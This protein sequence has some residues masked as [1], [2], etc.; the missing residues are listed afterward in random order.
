METTA[1]LLR[2]GSP[3]AGA[4]ATGSAFDSIGEAVRSYLRLAA[5]PEIVRDPWSRLADG[6]LVRVH[7]S[8]WDGE[9]RLSADDLGLD[10]TTYRDVLSRIRWGGLT[11]LPENG[12]RFSSLETRFRRLPERWGVAVHWGRFV[13]VSAWESFRRDWDALQQEWEEL[14]KA[15]EESYDS[16]RAAA[17]KAAYAFA[18]SSATHARRLG[19][20]SSAEEAEWRARLAERILAHYPPVDEIRRRFA[21]S[22]ET[23][24]IPR[25]SLDLE[26]TH[27][28]EALQEA[29]RQRLAELQRQATLA[30][31][32]DHAERLRLEREIDDM[33]AHIRAREA[34]IREELSRMRAEARARAQR[35]LTHFEMTYARQIRERLWSSLQHV[36]AA[37]QNGRMTPMATSSLR[38]TIQELRQIA[39]A[40][41]AEIGAMLD[42]LDRAIGPRGVR[43][44]DYGPSPADLERQ[45]ADMGMLLQTSIIALG[46]HVRRGGTATAPI[47][48]TAGDA[49]LTI[50]VRGAV[51]RLDLPASL[52]Q[53]LVEQAALTRAEL[54]RLS[55]ARMAEEGAATDCATRHALP[56]RRG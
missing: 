13:P 2:N 8:R 36:A 47:D 10:A 50:D 11:L 26:E 21:V 5:P 37:L 20:L 29:Q 18:A 35:L 56:D 53:T 46:G 27:R 49:P 38:R 44:R 9:V 23:A 31:L 43:R 33:T 19:R 14:L 4:T 42:R 22:Y 32:R 6:L 3:V 1:T 52:A 45:I 7:V 34:V 48:A 16:A 24:I 30:A 54:R 41:D 17:E 15:W 12:K 40:D 28:I 39:M 55:A 25:P 51:R